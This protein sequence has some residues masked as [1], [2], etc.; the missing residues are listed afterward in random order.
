M[1]A[2]NYYEILGVYRKTPKE[3]IKSA[4]RKLAKKYHPDNN[5]GIEEAERRFK[6]INEAYNTLSNPELKKKY[7]RVTAKYKYGIPEE[8]KMFSDVTYEVKKG[9]T[10]LN[11]FL[12]IFLGFKKEEGNKVKYEAVKTLGKNRTP[13]KGLNEET[14]ISI[15]L[16]EAFYGGEK[17]IIIKSHSP[18][19]LPKTF[20]A[21]IPEG[22]KNGDKVRLAGGG[23][24]GKNGG[25]NGDLI[26]TIYVTPHK[27]FEIVGN[28]LVKDIHITPWQA[29]LGAKLVTSTIDGEVDIQVPAGVQADKQLRIPSKG[30]KYSDGKRGDL[31]LNVKVDVPKKLTEEQIKLYQKLKKIDIKK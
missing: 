14:E 25:K 5:A 9:K 22:I 21:L 19:E 12:N 11:E 20:K 2:K 6:D 4:Y 3:E 23:K 31:L 29:A 7:D 13:I 8:E 17:K 16:E 30:F 1:K 27:D 10:A 15:T 26:V 18:S 28:D 24:A